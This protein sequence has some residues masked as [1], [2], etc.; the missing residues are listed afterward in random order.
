MSERMLFVLRGRPGL[1]HVVPGVAIAREAQRRGHEVLVLTYDNGTAFL[2]DVRDLPSIDLP[3]PRVYEDWP[4][5]D[6]YDDGLGRVAPVVTE[7]SPSV[8][9][10][11]GEYMLAPL[12]RALGISGVMIFN[13]EIMEDTP[14]NQVWARLFV[15]LFGHC[16]GLIP[17]RPLGDVRYVSRFSALHS[18]LLPAGPFVIRADRAEA[19]S[20]NEGLCILIA[21]GGGVSFPTSTASYSSAGVAASDWVE[22]TRT[23]TRLSVEAAAAAAGPHDRIHVFSCLG[24]EWNDELRRAFAGQ[25]SVTVHEPSFEYYRVLQRASVIISRSGAGF[26]ADALTTDAAVVLWALREHHE[27]AANALNLC[28]ERSATQYCST[29]EAMP[30]LVETAMAQARSAAG[31]RKAPPNGNAAAVVGRLEELARGTMDAEVDGRPY[32]AGGVHQTP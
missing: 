8:L 6:L 23:L 16:E 29:P 15:D 12:A 3:L 19:T 4:G 25:L 13:P 18:R 20:G 31:R 9:V 5:L 27:Q 24:A 21:N 30:A 32:A 2:Q 10:M 14:R 26:I 22:Q 11:G 17:L 28:R 7:F 1:G